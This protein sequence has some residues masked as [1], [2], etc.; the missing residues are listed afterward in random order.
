MNYIDEYELL[1]NCHKNIIQYQQLIDESKDPCQR[2]WYQNMLNLEQNKYYQLYYDFQQKSSE[3]IKAS[4]A[5]KSDLR[6]FTIEE[7]AQYDGSMGN[8]AYVAINGIVYDVSLESTWGGGTHFSLYAGQDLTNQFN[9]CHAGRTEAVSRLP[10]V[11]LLI[12]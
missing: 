5:Y 2:M 3:S 12:R 11:G 10:R 1:L 8:P 4:T 9:A 6:Q 7:L